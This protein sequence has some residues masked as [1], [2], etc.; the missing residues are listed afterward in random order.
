MKKL[1]VLTLLL[2]GLA[3]FVYFY[4]IEGEEGR[5]EA[6]KL[7]ESLM[8]LQQEDI[9]ALRIDREGSAPIVLKRSDEGWVLKEPL[10]TPADQATV[11]SLLKN[12]S[13]ARRVRS[14]E[15]GGESA[16]EYGLVDP[17][18]RLTVETREDKKVL[19]VGDKDFTGNELYVMFQ[20][21]S[22]VFLTSGLILSSIDKELVDWRDKTI[23]SFERD[24]LQELRIKRAS[25]EIV[26]VRSDD[27]WSLAGPIKEPADDGTV[28]SLLS[29]LET[30][31]AKEFVTEN[32]GDLKEFGL[33][34]PTLVVQV[35]EEGEDSWRQLELGAESEGKVFGRNPSRPAVFTVEKD[36]LKDLFKELWDFRSKEVVDVDQGQIAEV[37]IERKE[38]QLRVRHEDYK[39]M[40]ET[41][42]GG[43]SKEVLAY[44]FWYPIDDIEYET[45]QDDGSTFPEAE[46]RIIL[47]L[48]D[49]SIRNYEFARQ[50][51]AFLARQV[52]SGR[53]GEISKEDFEKLQFKLED[54]SS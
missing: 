20:G 10:E 35:R 30:S 6:R 1:A 22:Q 29:T 32:A 27:K 53:Q 38:S 3:T 4:E 2:V 31:K 47:T 8:R 44:K 17:A 15:K 33:E 12:L 16:S 43:A 37:A 7:E 11:D 45:I 39:W 28:S 52:E 24:S 5:E 23:L 25:E 36:V 50:G 34:S 26:L 9:E 41:P 51:D 13:D 49:G 54:I 19:L 48:N 42:E 46:V 21:D 14:F 18:V 40:L